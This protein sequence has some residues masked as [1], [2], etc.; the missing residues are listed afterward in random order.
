MLAKEDC[1]NTAAWQIDSQKKLLTEMDKDPNKVLIMILDMCNI[2]T[3]YL[4]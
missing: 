1:N 3:K 4:N 2:Y